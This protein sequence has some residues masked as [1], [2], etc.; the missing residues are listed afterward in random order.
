VRESRRWKESVVQRTA[1]M[2][3]A[4]VLEFFNGARP[5]APQRHEP[6][7]ESSVLREDAP[8]T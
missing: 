7:E 1:G 8:K 6:L 2:S 5:V 3:R 4:E